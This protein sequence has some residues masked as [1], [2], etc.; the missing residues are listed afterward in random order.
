MEKADEFNQW[1]RFQQAQ[2][3]AIDYNHPEANPD[4][5]NPSPI[6]D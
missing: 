6:G 5:G 2:E 4:P 3:V 1:A